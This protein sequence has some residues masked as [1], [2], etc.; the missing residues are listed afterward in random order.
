MIKYMNTTISGNNI[1][2]CPSI[3]KNCVIC[4]VDSKHLW[5]SIVSYS[6]SYSFRR[7]LPKSQ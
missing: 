2:P 4:D 1:Y 3:H 7:L 6:F 5:L